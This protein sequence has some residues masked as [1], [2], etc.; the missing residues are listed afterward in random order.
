MI[1]LKF[2]DWELL[3]VRGVRWTRLGIGED[4]LGERARG[5]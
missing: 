3:P 5:S 4:V 1:V 2:A